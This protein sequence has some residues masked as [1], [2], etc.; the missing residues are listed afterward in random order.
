MLIKVVY[1]AITIWYLRR[2]SV[3]AEFNAVES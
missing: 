3:R 2:P 1:Y